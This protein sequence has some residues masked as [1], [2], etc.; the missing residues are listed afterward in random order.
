MGNDTCCSRQEEMM[1]D[2]NY[3]NPEQYIINI[4]NNN[5]EFDQDELNI[6]E[7]IKT[8]Q[9][10]NNIIEQRNTT[11]TIIQNDEFMYERIEE[12]KSNEKNNKEFFKDK[13][14]IY[15]NNIIKE[16]KYNNNINDNLTEKM[17]ESEIPQD[18]NVINREKNYLNVI[19]ENKI[20]I[21]YYPQ[22]IKKNEIEGNENINNN[23]INNYQNINN[24]EEEPI[25]K[26]IQEYFD[27]SNE[28]NYIDYNI[29]NNSKEEKLKINNENINNNIFENVNYTQK[30]DLNN[31][32]NNIIKTS[33]IIPEKEI[34]KNKNEEINIV[35]ED[36]NIN[37][38]EINLAENQ[39]FFPTN[40][41]NNLIKNDNTNI[42][43]EFD[44]NNNNNNIEYQNLEQNN[45][46]NNIFETNYDIKSGTNIISEYENKNNINNIKIQDNNNINNNNYLYNLTS[47]DEPI[48]TDKEIDDL[49]KQAENNQYNN[50]RIIY[51][52]KPSKI[53]YPINLNKKPKII[54]NNYPYINQNYNINSFTPE[55][56]KEWYPLT[57][58]YQIKK[59]N[60]NDIFYYDINNNNKYINN[61]NYIPQIKPKI[62][63]IKK[64]RNINNQNIN[65]NYI[66]TPQRS[67]Q[68]QIIIQS[69]V[70]VNPPIIQY[71]S[72]IYKPKKINN[73]SIINQE[74]LK[75]I[76]QMNNNLNKSIYTTNSIISTN[77]NISNSDSP[78]KSPKKLDKYG[79]PIY[80]PS[81]QNMKNKYKNY[82]NLKQ[83]YTKKYRS[84]S[85]DDIRNNNDN[86]SNNDL[87]SYE[88][89]N[90]Q[91]KKNI[92]Y[93]INSIKSD[94]NINYQ[95]NNNNI[96]TIISNPNM[97]IIS[98]KNEDKYPDLDE[99]TKQIINKYISTD[100]TSTFNFYPD[101]AKLFYYSNNNKNISKISQSVILPNKQIKYYINNNPS[102]IAIYTGGLNQKKQRHGLGQ[103][104]EPNC[105]KIGSWKNDI[106]NGW[107]RIIYNTGQV[108]EGNYKNGKL[109]GKGVYKYKDTL[110]VGDFVNN[111]RHGNGI[112][113]N[114]KFRYKGQF[115]NGKINGYGKII[116]YGKK[117]GEGEYEGYFKDNNIEGKGIMKWNNGNIYQGEMKNGKMNGF[118]KFIPKK[119]IPFQG[120]FRNNIRVK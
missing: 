59:N 28:I 51:Q 1:S 69:P 24:N 13:N 103:L 53:N 66:T 25:E 41:N 118:G 23:I 60:Y 80:F 84:L 87:S 90:Y 57:P 114:K 7:Q 54:E 40:N 108:F 73:Q 76:Q 88:P 106:F 77:S 27:K 16:I 72:N 82:Q 85:N 33:N 115:N 47:L 64:S 102:K 83:S 21:S 3:I 93:G 58:D 119:G 42:N 112:L 98:S 14:E 6:I 37:Y 79:N 17:R 50:K 46:S 81:L 20:I 100:I 18:S 99:Q 29:N 55:K 5:S 49:I 94:N 86:L 91:N 95:N 63:I 32:N 62:E 12:P 120:F 109:N 39:T 96:S 105:I 2:L 30:D 110:Y 97:S 107:G 68:K 45:Y 43:Y 4:K 11:N 19:D 35:T 89:S 111:N 48:F 26:R 70:K 74:Y 8:N 116:F 117:E 15:D 78:L 67:N 36:N 75:S 38:P 10:N 52:Q 9:N 104:K 71:N 31:A 44:N 65:Y 34:N 101:N 113:L 61:I 56:K 22:K 92:N